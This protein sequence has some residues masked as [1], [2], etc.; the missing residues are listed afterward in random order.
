MCLKILK[1]TTIHIKL[2]LKNE[3]IYSTLPTEGY[4]MIMKRVNGKENC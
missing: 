4:V 3:N 1:M 2:K